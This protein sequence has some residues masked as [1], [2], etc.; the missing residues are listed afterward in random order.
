MNVVLVC[1]R[2]FQEYIL[3]NIDQLIKLNHQTIYVITEKIHF[4]NYSLYDGKIILIDA[5]EL[6]DSFNFANVSSLNKVFKNGFWL[7]T[8]LRFFVIYEFMKKYNVG[9]IIHLENDVLIYYNCDILQQYLDNNYMYIPFDCYMRNIASIMYIPDHHKFKIILDNY[10]FGRSDMDNFFAIQTKTNLIKK[11]PIF[12]T[13]FAI[14]NEEKYVSEHSDIF[15]YVF[16]AAAMG[17]YIGGVDP[18]NMSG[19]TSGFINE[20]CV[21]KYNKYQIRW[22]QENDIIKPFLVIDND[23]FPIFNLHIHCKNLKKYT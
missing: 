3:D 23:I 15:P 11:F 16:D 4:I 2:N 9:N 12:P 8:S 7:L 14:T 1:L 20:T 22:E 5:D 10:D 19:D 6:N 13:K 21:I 18:H 17:Q